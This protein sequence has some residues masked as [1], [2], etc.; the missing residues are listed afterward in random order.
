MKLAVTS[1]GKDLASQV[2]ERFGRCEFFLVFD[3][4]RRPIHLVRNEGASSNEGAGIR[5]A[6]TL[7]EMGINV[8]ITGSVGPNAFRSLVAAGIDVYIGAE[9][10]I[11]NALSEYSNGRLEKANGPTN[12]GHH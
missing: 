12:S 8:L 7:N 2:D 11:E 4:E 1:T 9:G 10:T 5:A 6:S 3:Q